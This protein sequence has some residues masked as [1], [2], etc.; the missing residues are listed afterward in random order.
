MDVSTPLENGARN[1]RPT[2]IYFVIA[3]GMGNT[4]VLQAGAILADARG[5][6]GIA[7]L[8]V[9]TKVLVGQ[10]AEVSGRR[11]LRALAIN[12]DTPV[13]A[14]DQETP[15]RDLFK[16]LVKRDDVRRAVRAGAAGTAPAV[17]DGISIGAVPST[18]I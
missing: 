14:A 5:E 10:Q 3:T 11:G 7:L 18:Y 4:M 15:R 6:K 9:P 16:E 1:P 2:D 17:R 8:I 13:R 12:H